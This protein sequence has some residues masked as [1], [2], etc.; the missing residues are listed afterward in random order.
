ME[1]LCK[2]NYIFIIYIWILWTNKIISI[3]FASYGLTKIYI[4]FYEKTCFIIKQNGVRKIVILYIKKTLEG[5][6]ICGEKWRNLKG[7]LRG[8][9][10]NATLTS[11]F[12]FS[13]SEKDTQIIVWMEISKLVSEIG[14][15]WDEMYGGNLY[16]LMYNS[17]Y[18]MASVVRFYVMCNVYVMCIETFGFVTW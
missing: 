14:T 2:K 16:L 3:I 10:K 13:T 18:I 4:N 5:F 15:N 8:P 1:V 11:F 6:Y 12:I 9:I 7:L 17:R